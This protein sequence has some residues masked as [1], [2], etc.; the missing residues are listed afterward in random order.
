MIGGAY[1]AD[2]IRNTIGDIVLADALKPFVENDEAMG[3][4]LA[5]IRPIIRVR[6]KQYKKVHPEFFENQAKAKGE[7]SF[8]RASV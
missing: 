8:S 7:K 1:Y 6:L 4:Q 5:K 2:W 3:K